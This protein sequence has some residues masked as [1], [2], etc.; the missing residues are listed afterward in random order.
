[1]QLDGLHWRIQEKKDEIEGIVA[2]AASETHT[3]LECHVE[4]DLAGFEDKD[5][6]GEETG[7]ALPYIVTIHEDSRCSF[8]Y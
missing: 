5:E 4:L 6:E 7:I 8:I 3:L 1:M 2:T